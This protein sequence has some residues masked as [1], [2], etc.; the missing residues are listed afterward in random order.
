MGGVVN[1]PAE[2]WLG[3]DL[4]RR[5]A[6]RKRV[7]EFEFHHWCHIKWKVENPIVILVDCRWNV[8]VIDTGSVYFKRRLF[9]RIFIPIADEVCYYKFMR[10]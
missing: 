8:W 9:L 3:I 7:V 4:L 1:L 2:L 5:K 6:F 10:M